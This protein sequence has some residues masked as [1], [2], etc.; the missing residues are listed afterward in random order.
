MATQNFRVKNG[1]EV[2][3]GA[4]ILVANSDGN[5]GIGTDDPF[6][7]NGTNLEV[8]HHTS[9]GASRLLLRN[10][11]Q[12]GLRYYIQSQND[13]ALTF[14]D[15]SNGERLRITGIGSVGI[16]SE[17][18]QNK[19]D[20]AGDVKILDNSPRLFFY[21]ANAN[22]ASSATGGFEVFDKDG[23]KN[24]FV[25][26][27]APDADNL[28]FGVTGSEKARITSGGNVGIGTDLTGASSN[29]KLTLQET[30]ST[31]CRFVLANTGS[32]SAE[33]TQIFSQNND[34]A[35][36]ANGSEKVRITSAGQLNINASSESLG[37]KVVIKNNVDYTAT[38]FDDNPTLYLLNGDQTTGISEASIVFAGRNTGGSTFRAAISG[39]GSTGLKFYAANNVDQNDDPVMIIGGSGNIGVGTDNPE[40]TIH[41]L[42]STN[43]Q[44]VLESVDLYADIIGADTGGSTRIRSNNGELIFH[45]G[46]DVSSHNANNS[47]QALKITSG[48]DTQ[49][50]SGSSLYIANG[51]LVFSTSGTGIDFSATAN[52]SGTMSS[53]LLDDYEEGS[54]TPDVSGGGVTWGNQTGSYVKIGKQ[55]I[56]QFWL[57]A[58]GTSSSSGGFSIQGLPFTSG[59]YSDRNAG[60]C[61]AYSLANFSGASG[62]IYWMGGA[63]TSINIVSVDGNGLTSAALLD[64]NVWQNGAEIHC[65]IHYQTA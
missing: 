4:T 20:V 37:G 58:S 25:G 31:A 53:E 12:S 39:N 8:A 32:D 44:L 3:I 45:T 50:S 65:T 59:S 11:D 21:D 24:V 34:L 18:P 48:G 49:V 30:G 35:F 42:A 60:A 29:T 26:A 5:V 47:S 63:T 55:V 7:T 40:G 10:T 27:F 51:N 61:R 28:I 23:N 13:G 1:L 64:H 9:S 54:W 52:S 6:S 62:V 16:G 15:I 2:G 36:Q 33:S 56:A 38:E 19:L 22:G 17:I 41:V 57:Q 43:N 14:G 46:G